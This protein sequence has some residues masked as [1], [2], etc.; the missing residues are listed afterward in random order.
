MDANTRQQEVKDFFLLEPPKHTTLETNIR[1][2]IFLG[3]CYP[4]LKVLFNNDILPL[5]S[6]FTIILASYIF[7]W[8]PRYEKQKRYNKRITP[9][10]LNNYLL[11]SCKTK[12]LERAIDYLEIDADDMTDQQF[13]VIPY[14]VFHKTK[15]I[16]DQYILRIK[17]D[18]KKEDDK[19]VED[20]F[21]N[22][23]YWNIQILILSKSYISFYFCGYNWLKDEIINERS[24]E[25]FYQ[26]MAT[27]KTETNEVS[28]LSKWSEEPITE[29]RI[30]KI[31]HNSGDILN[32]ITE[33]TELKQ[34]PQ[35]IV[36][37]EKI[38]KTIRILLRHAKTI[39]ESRKPVSIQFKQ[40]PVKEIVLDVE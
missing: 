10:K 30:T 2:V 20:Y 26:D 17:S 33:I 12:I 4:I 34:P 7:Y 1:V 25:Y 5:L 27:I 23:S 14:P 11:E 38:E 39:D 16:K 40:E 31:I 18:V 37:I 36:D 24:N 35:T 9:I 22:Y 3:V 29:A 32:L 6:W 15:N 13:I 19:D 28:F 21:Y 8:K